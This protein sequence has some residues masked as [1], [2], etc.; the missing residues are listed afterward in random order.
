MHRSL[1][2]RKN[3]IHQLTYT[4][5]DT[6]II[7]D[8]IAA[9]LCHYWNVWE[10]LFKESL[11]FGIGGDR[12]QHTLWQVECLPVTSHLKH[13]IIHCGTNNISNDSPTEI[14]NSIL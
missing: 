10:T 2:D 13:V 14:A 1:D 8:S 7:G 5:L 12:T 4:H 9:G 3:H 6:I 11:N